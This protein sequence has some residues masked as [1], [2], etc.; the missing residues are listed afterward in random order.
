M[1]WDTITDVC[2]FKQT[3]RF[4]DQLTKKPCTVL[5]RL[6]E[7]MRAPTAD[8]LPLDL[9]TELLKCMVKGPRDERLQ[10]PRRK[11]GFRAAVQWT[12]VLP[13]MQERALRENHDMGEMLWYVEAVD[14]PRNGYVLS[15]HQY[16]LALQVE[17][18]T[19]CGK[20]LGMLP[21]YKG[22][23]V[24]L[25]EV[26]VKPQ[27]VNDAVGTVMGIVHHED[28]PELDEQSLENGFCVLRHMPKAILVHFDDFLEDFGYG[29]GVMAVTTRSPGEWRQEIREVKRRGFVTNFG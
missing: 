1:F 25:T 13:L 15:A 19:V 11:A 2:L 6:L 22:M 12:S 5:P 21:V 20:R 18:M 7:F 14:I 10:E 4:V 29:P 26:F 24:R 3:C 9:W 23:V 16:Q 28:E 8:V 17:N 27:L